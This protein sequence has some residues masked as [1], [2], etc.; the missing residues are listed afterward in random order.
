MRLNVQE[1][2]LPYSISEKL[3]GKHFFQTLEAILSLTFDTQLG[4]FFLPIAWSKD[5]IVLSY[6]CVTIGSTSS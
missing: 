6:T 3:S 5:G 4:S 1:L 2:S